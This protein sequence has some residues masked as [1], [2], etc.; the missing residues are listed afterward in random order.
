MDV[1]TPDS[2]N[3]EPATDEVRLSPI[4][5]KR[6]LKKLARTLPVDPQEQP[7]EFAEEWE[8]ARE[9]FF[10]MQ[11]RTP[12][13]ATLAARAVAMNLRS[14]DM[15]DRAARPGTTD[16]KAQRLTASAI[17]AGR[18]LDAALKTLEK[19]HAKKAS[20]A[21]RPERTR[22]AQ[23]SGPTPDQQP[24]PIPHVEFFQPRDKTG[25]P[26]P[27]WRY[28]WMTMAQRRATYCYPRNPELEA[29]AIAEEEKMIAEHALASAGST[30]PGQDQPP[31]DAAPE[32]R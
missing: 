12:L 2:T 24:A 22:T 23:P 7:E 30:I 26:I 14:M 10:D 20:D 5:L 18:S 3:S 1:Q 15:L 32:S 19:R 25:Q 17:A 6:L 4:F 16:E 27:D 31:L 8:A 29:I 13:E 21:A 28:E 11:P 9:L